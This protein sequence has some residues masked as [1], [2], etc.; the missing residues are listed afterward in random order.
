MLYEMHVFTFGKAL[1]ECVRSYQPCEFVT[2]LCPCHR[3]EFVKCTCA[4]L[5]LLKLS[6]FMG[7]HILQNVT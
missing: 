4:T 5:V 2:C 3:D 1:R 6:V 7:A